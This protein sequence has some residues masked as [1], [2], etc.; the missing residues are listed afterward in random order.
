MNLALHPFFRISTVRYVAV[1][2]PSYRLIDISLFALHWVFVESRHLEQPRRSLAGF[3]GNLFEVSIFV[4]IAQ[5]LTS[6]PQAGTSVWS[7]LTTNIAGVFALQPT[8]DSSVGGVS[9]WIARCQS[10]IAW[11][12]LIIVVAN[13]IGAVVRQNDERS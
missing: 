9:T 3:I 7:T 13:L 12:L 6:T 4:T 11:F 1:I 2:I 10:A 5:V 8:V